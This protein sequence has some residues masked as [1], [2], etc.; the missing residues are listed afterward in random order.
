MFAGKILQKSTLFFLTGFFN[1]A[2]ASSLQER[3]GAF[4][5]IDPGNPIQRNLN[6]ES[7]VEDQELH[8]KEAYREVSEKPQRRNE[9]NVPRK[10]IAMKP[11]QENRIRDIKDETATTGENAKKRL[12]S[13]LKPPIPHTPLM[14]DIHQVTH[15][16][17]S[18]V[19]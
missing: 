10:G 11:L 12:P 6:K 2:Q 13:S 15:P 5:E 3:E 9:V 14:H 18:K 8:T 19:D 17:L 16:S 4:E 1:L 7:P